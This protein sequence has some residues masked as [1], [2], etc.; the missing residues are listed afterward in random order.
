VG[1][2][3]GALQVRGTLAREALLVL[4][5]A[6][7]VAGPGLLLFDAAALFKLRQA[8]LV[9]ALAR[10]LGIACTFALAQFRDAPDLARA[11]KLRFAH[12]LRPTARVGFTLGLGATA[13]VHLALRFGA[14]CRLD[15]T[16]AA[17]MAL[18]DG[19]FLGDAAP[20]LRVVLPALTLV[21]TGAEAMLARRFLP[22][23]FAAHLLRTL[24]LAS[25]VELLAPDLLAGVLLALAGSLGLRVNCG[26]AADGVLALLL[27]LLVLLALDARAAVVVARGGRG[28][29]A[30]GEGGGEGTDH[31]PLARVDTWGHGGSPDALDR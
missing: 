20:L 30:D 10:A 11:V 15:L 12:G 22:G 23:L 24:L 1:Q 5:M 8:R 14:P 3:A 16:G 13:R 31:E 21:R 9:A 18:L 28:G 4:E 17:R 2:A 25:A 19:A 6:V 27:A 26:P 7:V 29:D